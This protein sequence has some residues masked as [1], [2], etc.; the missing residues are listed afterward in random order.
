MSVGG[1]LC[2]ITFE[3]LSYVENRVSAV[4]HS[5]GPKRSA[6]I[7][8]FFHVAP[9]GSREKVPTNFQPSHTAVTAV[10]TGVPWG[11]NRTMLRD[12]TA[13]Y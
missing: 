11:F 8:G 4:V 12:D 1:L 10:T 7:S 9:S 5:L 6:Q 13:G 2:S 3:R